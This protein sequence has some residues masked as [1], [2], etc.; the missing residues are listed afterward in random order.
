MVCALGDAACNA[1]TRSK[2]MVDQQE[3]N[4]IRTLISIFISVFGGRTDF[5]RRF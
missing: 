3:K 1:S 2:P 5:F 4:E